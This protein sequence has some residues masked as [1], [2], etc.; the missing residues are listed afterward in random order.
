MT[1]GFFLKYETCDPEKSILRKCT[2][3]VAPGPPLAGL[4]RGDNRMA[5]R[6]EVAGGVFVLGVVAAA[7]VAAGLAHAQMHPLVAL[8]HALG[9]DVLF[10]L[11]QFA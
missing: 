11:E 6:A 1:G 7:H 3:H 2:V 5:G 8:S 9:A 10:I 4:G